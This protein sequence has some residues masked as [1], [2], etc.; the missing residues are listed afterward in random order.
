MALA[1]GLIFVI[2]SHHL[3]QTRI[4][5]RKAKDLRPKTKSF[6]RGDIDIE[7]HLEWSS[8]G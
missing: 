5:T 8:A 2:G 6:N 1:L 7:G 3:N 4:R